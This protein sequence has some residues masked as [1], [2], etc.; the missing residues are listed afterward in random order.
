MLRSSAGE[1]IAIKLM[2]QVYVVSAMKWLT[3]IASILMFWRI[4]P[5]NGGVVIDVLNPHANP[6]KPTVQF[7]Q[8]IGAENERNGY[9]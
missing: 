5:T 1:D 4:S 8:N 2:E 9:S 7:F 3:A 6:K